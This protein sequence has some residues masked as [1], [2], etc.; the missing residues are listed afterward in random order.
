MTNYLQLINSLQPI[1]VIVAKKRTGIGR[2]L[3]HYV[4]HLGNGVFVGNLKG[5]VKQISHCEL[6]EL[7]K[8]YEPVKVRRFTG[9]QF[10]IQQAISRATQKLGHKYSFL[11]FNCEHFANWVQYGKESSSQVT[12]G[13]LIALG[14]VTFKLITSDEGKR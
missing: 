7:L 5:C 2:I 11:G 1:D 4:V 14:F 12:N 3:D 13:F 8:E 10:Q 9:N 6:L